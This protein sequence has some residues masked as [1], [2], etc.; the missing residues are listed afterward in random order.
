MPTSRIGQ[1]WS[2]WCSTRNA[3]MPAGATLC[4]S[5]TTSTNAL[6]RH[7]PECLDVA[8]NGDKRLVWQECS[9]VKPPRVTPTPAVWL[10]LR[11]S[12]SATLRPACSAST[13]W[14]MAM[15]RSTWFS[16]MVVSVASRRMSSAAL[17]AVASVA[18]FWPSCVLPTPG[19]PMMSAMPPLGSPVS[20]RSSRRLRSVA[21]SLTRPAKYGGG[22]RSDRSFATYPASLMGRA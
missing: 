3:T 18:N 8:S 4:S 22:P 1:P 13:A 7:M 2:P 9:W 17:C 10:V 20:Q 16:S 15:N 19:T 14:A 11:V 5:S 12:N 6:P 21:S